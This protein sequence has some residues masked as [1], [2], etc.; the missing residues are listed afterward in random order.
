M[1]PTGRIFAAALR[2]GTHG[3]TRLLGFAWLILTVWALVDILR[4]SVDTGTKVMWVLLVLLFPFAGVILYF[5]L[6]RGYLEKVE[7]ERQSHY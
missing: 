5:A 6:G 1:T 7:R 2:R 4:R 3:M